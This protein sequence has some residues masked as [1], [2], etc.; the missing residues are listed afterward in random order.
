MSACLG[1]IMQTDT[2]V[3]WLGVWEKN[4]RAI[5]FYRKFNF[6]EVG[7]HVF[8]LGKDMQRDIIMECHRQSF[9]SMV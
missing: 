9:T 8:A 4:P 6:K 1:K 3:V 2:D 7:E 5:A